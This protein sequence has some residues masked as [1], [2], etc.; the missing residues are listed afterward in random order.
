MPT[1][2]CPSCFTDLASKPG[3]AFLCESP[4]C[5]QRPDAQ[6]TRF[7]GHEVQLKTVTP[8]QMQDGAPGAARPNQT[9]C[10]GCGIVTFTQ[11]CPRCHFV[12]PSN[13]RSGSTTCIAMVGARSSGKSFYIAVAKRQLDR[14]FDMLG[15][16][17][18]YADDQVRE[19][20]EN[21]YQNPLFVERSLIP[22]TMIAASA[23][24]ERAP[25]IFRTAGARGHP[26]NIVIRDSSGED[27]ER[28]SLDGPQFDFIANAD[29][30]I[31]LVDPMRVEAVRQMLTGLVPQEARPGGDPQKVLDSIA[32]K[33]RPVGS[34]PLR[35][36]IAL[37]LSKF[38]VL[39]ALSEVEGTEWS[40]IM[41]NDGA[42]FMRDPSMRKAAYD[43]R[44]GRLLH[45][46]TR[47]LLVKL[48]PPGLSGRLSRSPQMM[49]GSSLCLR[50]ANTAR[51]PPS[52]REGSL[53]SVAWTR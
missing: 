17:L 39:Q 14:L 13:W 31:F 26:H 9:S 45:E 37:A 36:P 25:L 32:T 38:D 21:S 10:K 5:A 34:P 53:L 23:P 30:L 22:P 47:S 12:L 35:V 33:L 19:L 42:A 49:C 4:H 18:A 28:G 29:A 1:T 40:E 7:N 52:I 24:R 3:T 46:E 43:D 27:L 8:V 48:E 15:Q 41:S 50:S 20:Y 11:V 51:A 16:P 44:D 6:A 2:R